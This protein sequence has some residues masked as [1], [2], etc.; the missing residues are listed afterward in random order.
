MVRAHGAPTLPAAEM[1]DH[2]RLAEFLGHSS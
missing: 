1:D 2:D